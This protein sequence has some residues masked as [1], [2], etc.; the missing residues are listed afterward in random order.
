MNDFPKI[1]S[2]GARGARELARKLLAYAV[3]S[4]VGGAADTEQQAQALAA[5]EVKSLEDHG[6]RV[7]SWS[8][9][10]IP[11]S[12]DFAWNVLAER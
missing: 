5:E 8:V 1:D 3:H 11:K 9:E 10:R 4:S 2:V 7:K 12:D 6:Y